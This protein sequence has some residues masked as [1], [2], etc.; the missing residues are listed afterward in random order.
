M[1]PQ[2]RFVGL[3]GFERCGRGSP[4]NHFVCAMI[5]CQPFCP[6]L[7]SDWLID[8][9]PKYAQQIQQCSIWLLI[10]RRKRWRRG[11]FRAQ[12]HS[13]WFPYTTH[14]FAPLFRPLAG[15]RLLLYNGGMLA[16]EIKII[17]NNSEYMLRLRHYELWIVV[18]P[19]TIDTTVICLSI[20]NPPSNLLLF[21]STIWQFDEGLVAS[22]A[23]LPGLM[24]VYGG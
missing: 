19:W 6:K 10:L 1:G 8:W 7:K 9:L 11:I 3:R 14:T 13:T 18:P 22:K 23:S 15:W 12:T 2:N 16:N 24:V 20:K 17:W 4:W 21:S 5:K